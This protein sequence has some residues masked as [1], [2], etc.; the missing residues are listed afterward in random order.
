[1]VF[2]PDKMDSSPK[3]CKGSSKMMDWLNS[4]KINT[5]QQQDLKNFINETGKNTGK[6]YNID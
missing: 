5:V 4:Y 1:M 3:N 6:Q 2:V